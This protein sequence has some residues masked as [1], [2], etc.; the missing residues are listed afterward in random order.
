MA[1]LA[2]VGLGRNHLTAA[3]RRMRAA[4]PQDPMAVA[5][6][7]VRPGTLRRDRV[8]GGLHRRCRGKFGHCTWMDPF[9]AAHATPIPMAS[10][11]RV[12]Q[13]TLLW[14]HGA[15]LLP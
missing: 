5:R 12:R 1:G 9:K 8:G 7:M 6:A 13:R 4:I 11:G 15:S 14:R 3:R 2:Y 10:R